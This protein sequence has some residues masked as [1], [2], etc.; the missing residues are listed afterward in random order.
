MDFTRLTQSLNKNKI[1]ANGS[2]A[3]FCPLQTDMAPT[4]RVHS[5]KM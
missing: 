4:C 1:K 5:G 2:I 3:I